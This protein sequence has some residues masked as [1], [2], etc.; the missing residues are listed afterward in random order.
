MEESLY[1][2]AYISDSGD[3]VFAGY[4]RG[5]GRGS[6]KVYDLKLVSDGRDGWL[7]VPAE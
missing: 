6:G 4:C 1:E 3:P 5:S 2:K 7:L